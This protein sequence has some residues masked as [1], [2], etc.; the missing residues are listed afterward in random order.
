MLSLR[1]VI[2]G[3]LVSLL[4]FLLVSRPAISPAVPLLTSEEK[5][6]KARHVYD[7][8]ASLR[9]DAIRFV[10]QTVKRGF[11]ARLEN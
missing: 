7:T 11:I 10:F 3:V 2:V 9:Y 8:R 6:K 4:L 5:K 1:R